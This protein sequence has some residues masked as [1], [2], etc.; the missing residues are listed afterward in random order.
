MFS[1][2][3]PT[4]RPLNTPIR[5]RTLSNLTHGTQGALPRLGYSTR[6][7]K[8]TCSLLTSI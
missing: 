8:R 5:P 6:D 2:L 1:T 3:K 7:R 4:P